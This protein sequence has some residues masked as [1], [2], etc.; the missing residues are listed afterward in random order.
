M[1]HWPFFFLTP[2]NLK[3]DN[4]L[5]SLGSETQTAAS[6]PPIDASSQ[7]WFLFDL[8]R[9]LCLSDVPKCGLRGSGKT[10]N[11]FIIQWLQFYDC[12]V[13]CLSIL[14]MWKPACDVSHLFFGGNCRLQRYSLLSRLVEAFRIVVSN[15]IFFPCL[16]SYADIIVVVSNWSSIDEKACS[17]HSGKCLHSGEFLHCQCHPPPS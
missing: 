1:K 16:Y 17:L 11:P 14:S 9:L 6:W 7:L 3:G 2:F 13:G 10:S 12:K 5:Y 8:L 15:Y 4:S